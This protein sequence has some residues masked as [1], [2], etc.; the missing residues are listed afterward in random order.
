MTSTHMHGMNQYVV[1]KTPKLTYSLQTYFPPE[2]KIN[3]KKAQQI[4]P[5][6]PISKIKNITSVY[7]T[8]NTDEATSSEK[9]LGFVYWIGCTFQKY[10]DGYERKPFVRR[11]IRLDASR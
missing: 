9:F 5:V 8:K 3:K 6:P 2:A 7:S 10:V 11:K 4:C 1:D